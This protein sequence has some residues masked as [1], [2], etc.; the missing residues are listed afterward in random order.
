MNSPS[1]KLFTDL[2]LECLLRL[3]A[4]AGAA[5]GLAESGVSR[6][7]F[8]TDQHFITRIRT[9]LETGEGLTIKKLKRFEL[10]LLEILNRCPAEDR[11]AA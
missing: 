10:G 8:G 4:D 6:A 11:K 5:T 2:Y 7:V 1:N 9:S 3:A